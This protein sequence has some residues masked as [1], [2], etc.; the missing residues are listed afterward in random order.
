MAF[1]GNTHAL[2]PLYALGV[3]VSF[4]LSQASMVRY[5]LGHRGPR[6]AGARP[7]LNGT[8]ALATGVV[9]IIIGITKFTH[10]AWIVVVLIPCM[11]LAV[12]RD[13]PALRRRG[14]PALGGGRRA[15][16]R[17]PRVT[18]CSCWWAT[19]TG[20]SLPALEYAQALSP[21][22]RG[23]YVEVDPGADAPV[24]GAVGASTRTGMPLV[25]LRLAR[26]GP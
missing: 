16:G 15:P 19:S 22:A 25:V 26:T 5:W 18:P 3:F 6:L 4:T 12:R 14:G 23:V 8:G 9:A 1:Q 2:I 7:R 17:R 11:I 13:P 24:R 10:G 21:T 20:A